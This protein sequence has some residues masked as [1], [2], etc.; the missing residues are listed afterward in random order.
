MDRPRW[1]TVRDAADRAEV[2]TATIQRWIRDGRLGAL[3][4][5]GARTVYRIHTSDLDHLLNLREPKELLTAPTPKPTYD[6]RELLESLSIVTGNRDDQ[7]SAEMYKAAAGSQPLE[8]DLQTAVEEV[9]P[10][11]DA[12][13]VDDIPLDDLDN[14]RPSAGSG[15]T[16]TLTGRDLQYQR[17]WTSPFRSGS[18]P[19]HVEEV[20]RAA[21]RWLDAELVIVQVNETAWRFVDGWEPDGV[22]T[23]VNDIGRQVMAGPEP[24]ISM[25]FP[26]D[27]FGLM[28]AS[29]IAGRSGS[30]G[31][32]IACWRPGILP[33]PQHARNLHFAAGV[34]AYIIRGRPD[35]W[36]DMTDVAEQC[37]VTEATVRRWIRQGQL[38]AISLGGHHRVEYRVHASDLEWFLYQRSRKRTGKRNRSDRS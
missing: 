33:D 35:T 7:L 14:L 38:P 10:V 32:I 8:M 15:P 19:A 18:A 1:L 24:V 4:L 26:D 22:G 31:W 36:L 12:R 28:V 20:C 5:G 6:A 2:S 29:R 27:Y 16:R 25:E 11:P 23:I 13:E 3:E 34:A 37:G 17:L 21:R 9:Q 30:A